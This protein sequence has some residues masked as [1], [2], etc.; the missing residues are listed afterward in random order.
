MLNRRF[1]IAFLAAL[2]SALASVLASPAL[3][4]AGSLHA[5][6]GAVSATVTYTGTQYQQHDLRLTIV[7]SGKTVVSSQAITDS[8]CGGYCLVPALSVVDVESDGEP[9][10]IVDLF[11]GGAHCCYL[12]QIY[13]FTG[14]GYRKATHDFGDSGYSLD[15]IA[16][17]YVFHT[18]DERFYYA[19]SAFADSGSPIQILA[20]SGS[21][22][23]DVTRAYPGLVK[24][25][26]A[27][28]WTTY[29]SATKSIPTET[30][31]LFT[32]W[33]ADE[34]LLGHGQLVDRT[35]AREI[36]NKR[37]RSD[38]VKTSDFPRQLHA[39][40]RQTGYASS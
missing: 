34:D 23:Y 25:D 5:H 12:A 19:F 14:H 39:F 4:S 29:L 24:K 33:A 22:F 38:F 10:V 20:L 28:W 32:A 15:R 40:L 26:A 2:A 7:R 30:T 18:N 31:G 17:S 11:T 6:A 8:A 13:R 27:Y 3:A 36:K 1:S 37:L 35:L 9:D 16:G 21:R